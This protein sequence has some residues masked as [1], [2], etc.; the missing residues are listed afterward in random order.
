MR[1]PLAILKTPK[2]SDFHFKIYIYPKH[3]ES[4]N[5]YPIEIHEVYKSKP[6][7][8]S[9]GYLN[10]PTN[11]NDKWLKIN[12]YSIH[13]DTEGNYDLQP[14]KKNNGNFVDHNNNATDNAL[15]AKV[16][17]IYRKDNEN[18]YISVN[19]MNIS[20][21]NEKKGTGEKTKQTII[22]TKIYTEDE[23][24]R[25][26]TLLGLLKSNIK[27][28]EK[29]EAREEIRKIQQ[30]GNWINMFIS[31]GHDFFRSLGFEIQDEKKHTKN[32]NQMTPFV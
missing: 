14:I 21:K 32:K 30:D 23:A 3:N 31:N 4:D 13:T 5:G 29:I 24:I 8:V 12:R 10:L 19:K 25:I 22:T 7:P 1:K 11:E 26:K 28:T 18:Q 2:I 20:F 16:R 17:F 6:M 15:N 9:K 27:N